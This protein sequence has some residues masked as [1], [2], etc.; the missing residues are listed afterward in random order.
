MERQIV[1]CIPI[2]GLNEWAKDVAN[3]NQNSEDQLYVNY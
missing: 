1:A 3:T 2:P